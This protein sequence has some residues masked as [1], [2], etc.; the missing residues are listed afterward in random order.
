MSSSVQTELVC[1]DEP[2]WLGV[3]EVI[4][5][6]VAGDAE[7]KTEDRSA[8]NIVFGVCRPSSGRRVGEKDGGGGVGV[9]SASADKSVFIV[10]SEFGWD[11]SRQFVSSSEVA[12]QEDDRT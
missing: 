7:R 3:G 2:L 4:F 9:R 8:H 1:A 11:D 5:E 12:L 10:R 6:F